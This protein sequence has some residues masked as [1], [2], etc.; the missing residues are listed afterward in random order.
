[1]ATTD[2]DGNSVG[3]NSIGSPSVTS[4]RIACLGNEGVPTFEVDGISFE[5]P[6]QL[7]NG[8]WLYVGRPRKPGPARAEGS[9]SPIPA[10]ERTR[11]NTYFGES[12]RWTS[13]PRGVLLRNRPRTS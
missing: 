5:A 11:S 12:P 10:S 4:Y 3:S 6:I 13:R 9:R 7:S 1:M 8:E 2:A